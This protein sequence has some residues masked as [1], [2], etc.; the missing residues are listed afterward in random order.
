MGEANSPRFRL[1]VR[2]KKGKNYT[3]QMKDELEKVEWLS[4]VSDICQKSSP[5][6][7][8]SSGAKGSGK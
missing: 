1:V 3:F 5:D 4:V 8:C 7:A 2:T 6:E